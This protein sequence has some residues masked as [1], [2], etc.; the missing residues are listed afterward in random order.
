MKCISAKMRRKGTQEPKKPEP[1]PLPLPNYAEAPTTLDSRSTNLTLLLAILPAS[2]PPDSP[3]CRPSQS[4]KLAFG[5]LNL[6]I[7]SGNEITTAAIPFVSR[8]QKGVVRSRE[9]VWG[10][11]RGLT[12]SEVPTDVAVEIEDAG[13]VG[14]DTNDHPPRSSHMHSIPTQSKIDSSTTGVPLTY[15]SPRDSPSHRV[16]ELILQFIKVLVRQLRR[17][18]RYQTLSYDVHVERME[19]PWMR[20][21]W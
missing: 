19:V 21:R 8:G 14:F 2:A 13:Y 5:I 17:V 4:C 3:L 16:L 1:S 12:D 9:W 11:E 18:G 10:S 7:S 15:S 20:F 6:S